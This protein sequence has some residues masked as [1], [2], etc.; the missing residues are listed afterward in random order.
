MPL[1]LLFKNTSGEVGLAATGVAPPT[2]FDR[3]TSPKVEKPSPLNAIAKTTPQAQTPNSTLNGQ[4]PLDR[5]QGTLQ[6]CQSHLFRNFSCAY[7]LINPISMTVVVP[8]LQKQRSVS[9]DRGVRLPCKKLTLRH[10][11]RLLFTS[12]VQTSYEL[13]VCRENRRILGKC[14]ATIRKIFCAKP[15]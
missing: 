3:Y 9:A 5:R 4:S 14:R 15:L 7:S 12:F 10:S 11:T 8:V 1:I 2:P 6:Q 13:D